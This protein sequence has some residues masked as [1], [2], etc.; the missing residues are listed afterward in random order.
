MP[1]KIIHIEKSFLGENGLYY[2]LYKITN[3]INHHF[4]FGKHQTKNL[5]DS[6]FGSG[7]VLKNAIK[8]YGKENFVFEILNFFKNEIDLNN[9]EKELL[10]EDLLNSD[11]CYNINYGGHGGRNK[12]LLHKMVVLNKHTNQKILID[13]VKYDPKYHITTC[14]GKFVAKDSDGKKYLIDIDDPR[15]LKGELVGCS[16][17]WANMINIKTGVLE[18]VEVKKCKET[19]RSPFLNMSPKNKNTISVFDLEGNKFYVDKNDKRIGKQLFIFKDYLKRR[20]KIKVRTPLHTSLLVDKNDPK[21]LSGEYID[22][23][24][25]KIK[26]KN[27]ITGEIKLFYRNSFQLN[28]DWQRQIIVKDKSKNYLQIKVFPDDP[29][30]KTGILYL[31]NE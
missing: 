30:L 15:Y 3:L 2:F 12:A 17:G 6:Y 24:E 13:V 10:T 22:W 21:Y 16:K 14:K 26:F 8:K 23:F 31:K 19:H 28:D 18:R 11:E 5:N 4:Y 25:Y 9:A 7:L 1:S 27:K 20:I 29:R